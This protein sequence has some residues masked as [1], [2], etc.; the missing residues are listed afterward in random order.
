MPHVRSRRSAFTLIELLVV[1]AIIALLISLLMP[2]L[3]GAKREGA[4]VKCLTNLRQHAALAHVNSVQDSKNRLHVPHDETHEDIDTVAGTGGADPNAY[5]MGAGDYDW[6]GAN[7]TE[8]RFQATTGGNHAEGAAGRF[9]NKILFGKRING[10]ED[11]S[12]FQCPGEPGLDPLAQS[13]AA[14]TAAYA[15]STFLATGNGYMGDYYGYKDHHWDST[16]QVYRRF[17]PYNRPVTYFN[18]PGRA[19]LFWEPRFMQAVSNSTEIQ[20]AAIDTWAGTLGQSPKEIV[21]AHGLRGR[22]NATFADGHA[23]TVTMHKTGT[24]TPPQAF[25]SQSLWWKSYWRTKEWHYDNYPFS[26]FGRS[27]FNFVLPDHY[28]R[29]FGY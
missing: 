7:G 27:W 4:R 14:P 20:A 24:L 28:L 19:L 10:N 3:S 25:S 26:T 2:A 17:G 11:Y 16:G 18:D 29:G 6:G 12:L 21:G 13:T 8:S 22:F 15:E 5:W 9:M 23:S 1:I